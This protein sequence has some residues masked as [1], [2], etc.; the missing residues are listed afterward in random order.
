MTRLDFEPASSSPTR[1][2]SNARVGGPLRVAFLVNFLAPEM[3]E[4]C[5]AWRDDCDA[6]RALLSVP[7]EANRAW[8][9][10]HADLDVAIQKTWTLARRD[11]H[12]TGY[13]DVIYIHVPLDTYRQLRRFAPRVVV[14]TELGVRSIMAAAYRRLHPRTRLVIAVTTSEHVEQSRNGWL[15]R[16]QRRWLLKAA[17]AVTYNGQSCRR[18]LE[19]L[20]VAPAKLHAWEYAADPTKIYRGPLRGPQCAGNTL[21]LLTVGQLIVRKGVDLAAGQLIEFAKSRPDA[22]IKWTLLGAGPLEGHLRRLHPPAN[23]RIELL[24]NC[25]SQ[26]L[27]AAYETHECLLFPTLGDEW[28]LVVEEAMASG[29][30]V[31]GSNKA[32]SSQTLIADGVNGYLYDP[33]RAG[34]LADKLA[35]WASCSPAERMAMR[36]AARQATA[37]RSPQWAAGQI[38]D[39]CHRLHD[40]WES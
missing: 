39:L 37:Q 25:D 16:M 2:E 35:A 18:Y 11:R 24:G 12:P 9:A 1:A 40:E 5:R 17:D 29:L 15:R 33:R 26:Q 8:Q 31:I 22:Q 4:V 23:L 34:D 30:A 13:E 36:Q 19:N 20:G 28:G 3:R 21:S 6:F 27:R 14:A 10:Q 32:Q 7:M 38:S